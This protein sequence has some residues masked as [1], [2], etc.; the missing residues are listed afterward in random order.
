MQRSKQVVVRR[1]VGVTVVIAA[2]VVAP[3]MQTWSD[4]LIE[5]KKLL[6]EGAPEYEMLSDAPWAPNV[7]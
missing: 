4:V 6:V 2:V 7:W 5:V 1:S 3:L